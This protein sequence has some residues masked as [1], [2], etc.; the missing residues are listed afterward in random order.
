M[1]TLSI[2]I[3]KDLP[4]YSDQEIEILLGRLT[5]NRYGADVSN[6]CA[7]FVFNERDRR[8][9]IKA[10]DECSGRGWI[11]SNNENWE[12]ETQKCDMCQVYKTDTEAQQAEA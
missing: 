3:I 5:F 8:D 12:P 7:T 10:C 2:Q 4:T 9:A 6:E 1:N 11:N